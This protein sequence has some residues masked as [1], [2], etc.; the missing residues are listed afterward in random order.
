MNVH[1]PDQRSRPS[2]YSAAELHEMLVTDAAARHATDLRWAIAAY[3]RIG[4]LTR[5]GAEDAF[6][7]VLDDVEA[8]TGIRAMPVVEP[9]SNRELAGHLGLRR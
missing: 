5:R 3:D 2:S 1:P 9:T 4:Q 8:R 6:Q 7:A